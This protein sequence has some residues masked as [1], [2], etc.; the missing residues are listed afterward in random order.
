V[1]IGSSQDTANHGVRSG[2]AGDQTNTP[3]ITAPCITAQGIASSRG[4]TAQAVPA[5]PAPPHGPSAG[6]QASSVAIGS[7]EAERGAAIRGAAMATGNTMFRSPSRLMGIWRLGEAIGGGPQSSLWLAQPA[8]SVGNPRWDY[9]VRS[10]PESADRGEAT[11]QLQRFVAAAVTR[12]PHLVA[13]LDA[14]LHAAEPF[15][16]MPRLSDRSLADVLRSAASQPLPVVLWLVRQTAE[17]AWALHQAGFVHGDIKPENVLISPR[18]HATLIDLGFARRIGDQGDGVFR[19]SVGFA[20][21]ECLDGQAAAAAAADSFAL[22]RLLWQLLSLTDKS[23]TTS[24]GID[25]VADLVA[26]L[27]DTDPDKRPTADQLASRLIRL[28][29]ETL[30]CHIRPGRPSHQQRAA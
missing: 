9:V 14:S 1:N 26:D 16:V 18:G 30:G 6:T 20:A 7:V 10:I 29:I 2:H 28:E 17:A 13:V 15:I 24:A 5:F 27:V 19:G 23:V 25:A 12:H 8:D 4:K 21:P 11:A 3:C 22:G